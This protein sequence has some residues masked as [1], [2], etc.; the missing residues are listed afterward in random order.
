MRNDRRQ[1]PRS[2]VQLPVRLKGTGMIRWA[3]TLT[4]DLSLQGFRCTMHGAFWPVGTR[5]TFEVPLFPA[6]DPMSGRARIIHLGEIPYSDRHYVG[7]QF[8]DLSAD[9]LRQ[10]QLY[11]NRHG[12]VTPPPRTK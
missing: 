1:V 5:V 12:I 3:E 6:E 9:A 11:L 2:S 8:S 10:L 4:K 7:L